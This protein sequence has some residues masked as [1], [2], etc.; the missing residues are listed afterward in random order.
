M[1]RTFQG[2]SLVKVANKHGFT[3][4]L[5]YNEKESG[6][7]K[8]L[9]LGTHTELPSELDARLEA[10]K[11]VAVI[12]NQVKAYTVSQL[13]A[14]YNESGQTI[15]VQTERSYKSA[16][17]H[18]EARWGSV[19]LPEML[20]DLMA[21]NAWLTDLKTLPTRLSPARPF[22]KK[23]KQN[24]KALLHRLVNCAMLWG[25][26]P[27]GPNPIALIE[28]KMPRGVQVK[29]RLKA[30]LSVPQF[31]RLIQDDKLPQHVKVMSTVAMFLGLRISEILSLRW[32][33]IDFEAETIRV[34][35]SIVGR[36][37]EGT[38]SD[39]SEATMPLHP[40]LAIILKAWSEASEVV[41]GWVFGSVVTGRP[42][43]RDSLQSDHLQ[44]AGL[45][46]GVP[47]LGWH[48]FRHT[49]RKLMQQF[50]VQSDIQQMLMRHADLR[51]TLNYGRDDGNMEVKRAGNHL[52]IENILKLEGRN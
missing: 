36:D 51:T 34:E 29:K 6:K 46:I 15:R 52:V 10:A 43:H 49:Y 45:R 1:K 38:K 18:I 12:N 50:G 48:T 11:Q 13:I 4:V 37:L 19:P 40:H 7:R 16:L 31:H 2:G 27:V 33:D 3:W 5:R 47:G 20:R 22:S 28:V 32:T 39:A 23:T 30:P 9:T 21:V 44:P 8:A 17:K 14:K 24:V 35:R 42:F 25:Y 41:N 26:L